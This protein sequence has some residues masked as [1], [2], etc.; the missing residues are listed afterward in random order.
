M[1]IGGIVGLMVSNPFDVVA[2]KLATQQIEKYN[3]FIDAF[4]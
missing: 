1:A 3:G 2:T 4:K